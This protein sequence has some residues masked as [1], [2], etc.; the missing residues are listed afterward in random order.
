MKK[1]T[2]TLIV[3][4]ALAASA[5]AQTQQGSKFLGGSFNFSTQ[6]TSSTNNGATTL[7]PRTNSIQLNPSVGYFIADNLAIGAGF[8]LG[9]DRTNSRANDSWS[10]NNSIGFLPFVRYYY[11]L[12][13]KV[14]LF[15][16]ASLGFFTGRDRAN[17]GTTTTIGDRSNVLSFSAGG[18]LALFPTPNFSIDLGVNI[19][20][21]NLISTPGFG[22]ATNNFSNIALG[23]NTLAPSVG[24]RYFF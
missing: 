2:S 23:G 18:G 11:S 13:E 14:Y 15:S 8:S 19:L 20:N 21:M 10:G 22:G 7:G 1:L 17:N 12:D 4:I 9:M 6:T 16:Q 5:M 24:I 3:L